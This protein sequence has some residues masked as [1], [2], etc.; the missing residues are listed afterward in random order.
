VK[1]IDSI[2]SLGGGNNSNE[3]F[4]RKIYRL[5]TSEEAR[6]RQDYCYGAKEMMKQKTHWC[7]ITLRPQ[8]KETLC[9]FEEHLWSQFYGG[10]K[11]RTLFRNAE[12]K[13]GDQPVV[14]PCLTFKKR[15]CQTREQ[16]NASSSKIVE[17][18]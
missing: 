5:K 4:E 7:S 3:A 9:N 18:D 12:I 13:K 6:L 17:L 11:F 15:R 14:V 10:Q 1:T 2:Y 16:H 8:K